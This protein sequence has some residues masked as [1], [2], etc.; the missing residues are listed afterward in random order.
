M[1]SFRKGVPQKFVWMRVKC[2][3]VRGGGIGAGGS[4]SL[5]HVR[6]GGEQVRLSS[7]GI[8]LEGKVSFEDRTGALVHRENLLR[9]VTTPPKKNPRTPAK[10]FYFSM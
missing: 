5:S 8:V 9:P 3:R 4:A 1:V 10:I 2:L 7:R 6:H